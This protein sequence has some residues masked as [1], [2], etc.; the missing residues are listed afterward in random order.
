MVVAVAFAFQRWVF[1]RYW[2]PQMAQL[3]RPS[4]RVRALTWA[5]IGVLA[6]VGLVLAIVFPTGSGGDYV[7]RALLLVALV[8]SGALQGR[9]YRREGREA[10]RPLGEFGPPGWEWDGEAMTWRPPTGHG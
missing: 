5:I 2:R 10:P 1:R 6:A 4:W 8:I 9:R 3:P 7:V